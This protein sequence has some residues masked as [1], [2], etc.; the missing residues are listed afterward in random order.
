MSSR[1]KTVEPFIRF[2]DVEKIR[3]LE[4]SSRSDELSANEI[5]ETK[6][7]LFE[8]MDFT[9]DF[10]KKERRD[11][12][13]RPGVSESSEIIKQRIDQVINILIKYFDIAQSD[14][15]K[16]SPIIWEM[17]SFDNQL[18]TAADSPYLDALRSAVEQNRSALQKALGTND[19]ET[20]TDK[21]DVVVHTTDARRRTFLQVVESTLQPEAGRVNTV[22][23]TVALPINLLERAVDEIKKELCECMHDQDS[24]EDNGLE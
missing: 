6:K 10:R 19:L 16:D 11:L 24:A 4:K 22:L 23:D 12:E 18:L 17:L 20:F 9:I 2:G 15:W 3:R 5:D 14:Q 1:A 7:Q 21:L 13:N 8:R